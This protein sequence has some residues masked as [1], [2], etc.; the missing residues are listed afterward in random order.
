MPKPSEKTKELPI[1][2][3]RLRRWQDVMGL[4]NRGA[5]ECFGIPL[6]TYSNALLGEHLP[7][8]LGM[9]MLE[10]ILSDSEESLQLPPIETN[11]EKP[12]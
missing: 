4:T 8:G 12:N 11:T 3:R 1:I 6:R 5:A 10:K 2:S 7:R 9:R